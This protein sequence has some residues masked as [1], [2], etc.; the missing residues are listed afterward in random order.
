MKKLSFRLI[1]PLLLAFVLLLGSCI[2]VCAAD[3][4]Y[5]DNFKS[6]GYDVVLGYVNNSDEYVIVT[7]DTSF[8][9]S[10]YS[11]TN[12]VLC[13]PAGAQYHE[14]YYTPS[15]SVFRDKGVKTADT[16]L[17]Y[18]KIDSFLYVCHSSHDIYYGNGSIFFR[19]PLAR[20]A[21]PL[22]AE[23]LKQTKIILPVGVGCLALL[24]GSVV[25]LPRLRRS[26]L[27]L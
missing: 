12:L 27:R 26:L 4:S 19:V 3:F 17:Y 10:Q 18:Q 13:I 2:T 16:T 25:L 11:S 24:T 21:V 20:L 8:L 6:L 5:P 15:S 7:S 9:A 1:L 23:V 14:W 22:K